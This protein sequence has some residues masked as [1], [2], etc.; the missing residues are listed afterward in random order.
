MREAFRTLKGAADGR[1]G[2][3]GTSHEWV[4]VL[5]L[6]WPVT[7]CKYTAPEAAS[8]K[9]DNQEQYVQKGSNVMLGAGRQSSCSMRTL[10]RGDDKGASIAVLAL[11]A[12]LA[13]LLLNEGHQVGHGALHDA[14][15]LDDLRAGQAVRNACSAPE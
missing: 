3:H 9:G 2:S 7:S 1:M 4:N 6:A 14:G 11:R 12:V 5:L 15:G 8:N 10:D 13:L